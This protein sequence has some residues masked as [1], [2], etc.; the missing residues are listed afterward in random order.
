MHPGAAPENRIPRLRRSS[1]PV[2][3]RIRRS[4]GVVEAWE[5]FVG[6]GS[7][8]TPGGPSDLFED[9]C[10]RLKMGFC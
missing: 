3:G 6:A 4:G 10:A 8:G 2:M 1:L 9:A 5:E 7:G